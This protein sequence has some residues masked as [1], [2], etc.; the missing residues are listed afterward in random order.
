MNYE[1]TYPMAENFL[2]RMAHD[3]VRNKSQMAGFVEG[4]PHQLELI[5]ASI[6]GLQNCG[7]NESQGLVEPLIRTLYAMCEDAAQGIQAVSERYWQLK[8]AVDSHPRLTATRPYAEDT[9]EG[10]I[11]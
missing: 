10:Y 7:D 8:R 2:S 1:L 4:F 6:S 3:I 9:F 11:K 5:N